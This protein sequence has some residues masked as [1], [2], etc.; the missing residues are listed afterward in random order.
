MSEVAFS[1][2]ASEPN[3]W[4]RGGR[5]HR[6]NAGP[7][8]GWKFGEAD[9]KKSKNALSKSFIDSL[10]DLFIHLFI[11]SFVVTGRSPESL[12]T[13]HTPCARGT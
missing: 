9:T 10:I 13:E 8:N 2:A 6:L 3:G 7:R 5:R 1:R 12:A 4:P 11:D